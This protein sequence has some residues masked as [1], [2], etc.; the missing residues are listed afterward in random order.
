MSHAELLIG[1]AVIFVFGI[2]A[3][4]ISSRLRIPSILLL[5]ILGFVAGPVTGLVRPDE[6]FGDLFFIIVPLAVAVVLFEGGTSLSISEVTGHGTVVRRLISIGVLVT[7]GLAAGAAVTIL[8]LEPGIAVLLGAV[9]V[10]SGPTVVGP[11]LRSV[12]PTSSVRT[13]LNW[14]GILIDPVGATLAVIVFDILIAGEGSL[15]GGLGAAI[16]TVGVGLLVGLIGAGVIVL[17][18]KRYLIPDHLQPSATLM[19]VVAAF[20]ASDLL[21]P[22]SGLLAVTLMGIAVA[23]QKFVSV[24]HIIEFKETLREL[25]IAGLFIVLAARLEMEDILDVGWRETLFLIVLV[26][27]AR[28]LAVFIST[29]GS[30]LAIRERLFV[31]W[32]APRGIVAAAVASVFA[33]ELEEAG[34]ADASRLVPLTFF[35]I[36]GTVALYSLTARLAGKMLGVV[37][38]DDGG[39]V[40]VG[41]N[42]VAR[43][44]A[45][46]VAAT[47]V[48]VQLVAT[49][50]SELTKARMEGL[51]A[52]R[53][54][55]LDDDE[56]DEDQAGSD[57]LVLL[58]TPN[59]EF[60][61]LA[62]IR[63]IE[64]RDRSQV[65]QLAPSVGSERV[66]TRLRARI[67]VS[68]DFSFTEVSEQMLA[69]AVFRTTELTDQFQFADYT[70]KHGPSATPIFV[71]ERGSIVGVFSADS[72]PSPATG[73]TIVSLMAP[74]TPEPP[75]ID[76]DEVIEAMAETETK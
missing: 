67:L 9:V 37:E 76:E 31:S 56:D 18:L 36:I 19:F 2:G 6:M 73:Q 50:H 24:E 71:I 66:A 21:R 49:N 15:R 46:T 39:L 33:I 44:L 42:P 68:L 27:V 28:P 62:A 45:K 63:A 53:T 11:L 29:I 48:D 55:V 26:F 13:V 75:M 43:E 38:E 7:W 60:N 41:A 70:K 57:D 8:G 30:E 16:S 3:Q 52:F 17:L 51:R 74:V 65:Y 25:L 34:I 58:A 22:E 10:V 61:A 20:V 47:G 72:T 4:W 64:S 69:G 40:I 12:K 35:V 5:L 23:N 59:D 54:S 1:I 32:V 14:E